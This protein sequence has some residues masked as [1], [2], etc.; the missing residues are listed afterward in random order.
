MTSGKRPAAVAGFFYPDDPA[1][2]A[3]MVDRLL[4]EAAERAGHRGSQGHSASPPKAMIVPHA[5]YIYSGAIAASAYVRLRGAR[6]IE[7][8]VLVGPAHRVAVRGIAQEGSAYFETPLGEIAVDTAAF[9]QVPSVVTSARAHAQEHSLEVQLPFL[10]RVL[11]EAKIVPMVFG[12]TSPAEV[13]AVLEAL[14]GGPETI[15]L[16]SSDLSHYLGYDAARAVDGQTASRVI[17]LDDELDGERACG[18]TGIRALVALARR[19]HLR[20]ELLDIRNSG[21]TAGDKAR[22][23]GYAAFAFHNPAEVAH[24]GRS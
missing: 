4:A 17:E 22:V 23:V 15:L 3:A 10:Q 20:A 24:A 12:H 18:V 13:A 21:D 19:H 16:V 14:W 2:L 8:V 6:G 11:P 9:A 7:R 5:G 1:T